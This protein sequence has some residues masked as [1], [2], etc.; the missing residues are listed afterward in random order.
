MTCDWEGVA[1]LYRRRH[2]DRKAKIAMSP[3]SGGEPMPRPS[4][5]PLADHL[6]EYLTS[7]PEFVELA[8]GPP[9]S[10][11]CKSAVQRQ[12]R[13][14]NASRNCPLRSAMSRFC[15]NAKSARFERGLWRGW[16]FA[17]G[18]VSPRRAKD[19]APVVAAVRFMA[20]PRGGCAA[21]PRKAKVLL[22]AW[23]ETCCQPS[24]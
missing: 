12:R 24:G 11:S 2:H 23:D 4:G 22:A 9:S 20:K 5:R 6:A 8:R 13:L 17:G 16:R 1:S 7:R 19:G 10:I 15:L 3:Q 14:R 18:P 21:I